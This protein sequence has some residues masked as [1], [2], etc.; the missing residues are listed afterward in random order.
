[1][2]KH[3]RRLHRGRRR[4]EAGLTLIE[5]PS[6]FGHFVASGGV[7]EHVLVVEA[8]DA[9]RNLCTERGWTPV[10]VTPEVLVAVGDTVQPQSPVAVIP[11]PDTASVRNRDTLVLV[12]ISD[13][14]NV[15]T[16]IRS[17]AAFGW[18]LAVF[19]DTAD[20]WSPKVLRAGVRS[21]FSSHISIFGH[22][23]ERS[24]MGDLDVV[25]SVV[26][27]GHPPERLGRPIALLVGSEAHGLPTSVLQDADRTIML[28]MPGGT[29]SLNAAVSGSILMYALAR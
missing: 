24:Q 10:L 1:L 13:P 16:M 3:T 25:A 6:V 12:D 8:D 20:P 2:I 5:G 14:G 9:S 7:P 18:D 23:F 17:A 15:G 22:P 29:E 4:R 11:I 26:S 27:G 28:K 21:H 19:G